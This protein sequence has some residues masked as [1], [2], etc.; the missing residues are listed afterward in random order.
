[1][2]KRL[3]RLANKP[4]RFAMAT[5]PKRLSVSLQY[6]RYFGRWPN[7][8]EPRSFTEKLQYRKLYDRDP[9]LA[10]WSDKVAVKAFVEERL[11]ADFVTPTL[12]V[13]KALPP[14]EHRN[15]PIPYVIKSNHGSGG[16]IFVH[17]PAD[18]DWPA[19]ER[20]TKRWMTSRYRPHVREEHY[21]DIE[22]QILVEP[23]IGQ[24]GPPIDYKFF[25]FGDR[26][27]FIL[28]YTGRGSDLRIQAFDRDWNLLPCR[29][30]K[31][32]PE[33]PPAMPQSF[34]EMRAAA[35]KLGSEFSFVRVD[36]YEVDGRPR[37][38]EMTFTPGSGFRRYECAGFD[39]TYG[40][41]WDVSHM[42]PSKVSA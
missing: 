25:V 18:E 15:W 36:F 41:L 33:T 12:A 5:L 6:F 4:L 14:I 34:V 28:V 42:R 2:K 38:G 3:T 13:G 24:D 9:R 39:L 32:P 27:A 21:Y 22:P 7:L 19:I 20:E 8:D 10:W 11:G 26:T 40:A 30:H 17:S 29:Y 31:D 35:E 23:Y 1:M 37:F 16:N